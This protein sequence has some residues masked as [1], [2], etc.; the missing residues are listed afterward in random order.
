MGEIIIFV[1]MLAGGVVWIAPAIV[2]HVY[3]IFEYV[4]RLTADRQRIQLYAER[5]RAK[6]GILE[7]RSQI[8]VVGAGEGDVVASPLPYQ[9][10]PKIE[11]Q[12]PDTD[13]DKIIAVRQGAEL[14]QRNVTIN[15]SYWQCKKTW[16]TQEQINKC[17]RLVEAG[18]TP[19]Q[20]ARAVINPKA[21]GRQVAE[22]KE[23]FFVNGEP[24]PVSR[25]DWGDLY[26]EEAA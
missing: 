25:D 6:I 9:N 15:G 2:R 7:F 3:P 21:G 10:I 13:T 17:C 14:R 12:T 11:C 8:H 24:K 5:E 18:K 22:I 19:T 20:I 1:V 16:L 4:N 26:Q 23:I